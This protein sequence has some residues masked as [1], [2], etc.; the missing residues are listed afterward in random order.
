MTLGPDSPGYLT[1]YTMDGIN[2]DPWAAARLSTFST[3][4]I[5]ARCF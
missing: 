2:Y 5:Q 3:F 1:Y 4:P